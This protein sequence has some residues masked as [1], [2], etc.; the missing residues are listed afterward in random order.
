M[1]PSRLKDLDNTRY[2]ARYQLQ[3]H[4]GDEWVDGMIYACPPEKFLDL[5]D[6]LKLPGTSRL[7]R[8]KSAHVDMALVTD[9]IV[10][11]VH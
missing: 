11:P 9:T 2:Y 6:V 10:A 7:Q 4:T 5:L 1:L 3:R 8:V